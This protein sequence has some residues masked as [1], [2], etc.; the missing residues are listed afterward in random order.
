[1]YCMFA[2]LRL[3]WLETCALR[4]IRLVQSVLEQ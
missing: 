1:M 3:K 4:Q 2:G